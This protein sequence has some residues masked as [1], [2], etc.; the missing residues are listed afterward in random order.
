MNKVSRIFEPYSV[1]RV[2][3]WED[4]TETEVPTRE[5]RLTKITAIERFCNALAL[6]VD[7]RVRHPTYDYTH[8]M[9]EATK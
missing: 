9:R 2:I 1:R 3:L 5:E 7:P 6:A 8:L 4:G